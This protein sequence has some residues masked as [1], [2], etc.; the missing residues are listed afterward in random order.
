M[1]QQA[2]F[3]CDNSFKTQPPLIM[4]IAGMAIAVVSLASVFENAITCFTRVRMVKS[5]GSDLQ[6]FMVRLEVLHLRL[7]RWGE[8]LGL[9]RP[10]D[11]SKLPSTKTLTSEVKGVRDLLKQ[12]ETHFKAAVKVVEDLDIEEDATASTA[13]WGDTKSLIV[14]MRDL[15]FKRH[16]RTSVKSKAKW[17]IYQK[18]K[19]ETLI[20]NLSKLIN[21]LHHVLPVDAAILT[22]ACENETDQLLG[23]ERLHQASVAMLEEVAAVLDERLCDAIARHKAKVSASARQ[24]R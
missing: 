15:S 12:I 14:G 24:S 4:E 6:F 19:L 13:D 18:D 8:A 7:S 21:D 1:P 10:I 5:F 16:P 23:S 11:N 22:R 2:K 3:N 17:V 20:E 9:N